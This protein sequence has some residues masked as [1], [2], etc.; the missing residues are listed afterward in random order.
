[1]L[2]VVILLLFVLSVVVSKFVDNKY[3]V[4]SDISDNV[5]IA[6]ALI[7]IVL[8]VCFI[9]V[10]FSRIGIS[11]NVSRWQEQRDA[12]THLRDHVI[13]KT[14]DD[15]AKEE[16]YCKIYEWNRD[17]KLYK[18]YQ[19]NFWVGVFIPDVFDQFDY[20]EY[21]WVDSPSNTK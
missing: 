4:F 13:C 9:F 15:A 12:I 19:D 6:K 3:G 8:I 16:L 21:G 10:I 11:L 7:T 1:M 17:L 5:S 2:L 14:E 18:E 20:I